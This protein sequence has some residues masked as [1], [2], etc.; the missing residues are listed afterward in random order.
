M[1][2]AETTPAPGQAPGWPIASSADEAR[3]NFAFWLQNE[4]GHLG[5]PDKDPEGAAL[6]ADWIHEQGL[7]YTDE[8]DERESDAV[9]EKVE[10][11]SKRF[12]DL[13]V[14]CSLQLHEQGVLRR[15]FRRPIPVLIHELEYHHGV[16]DQCRR[17]HPP[18]LA[19]GF[20]NWIDGMYRR[21][22]R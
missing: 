7:W 19:D 13:L 6:G 15:I 8:E 1:R 2:V 21:S 22:A 4:L 5:D 17:A 16:A 18:G 12:I 20:I 10:E 3:W 11:I 14:E 9:N